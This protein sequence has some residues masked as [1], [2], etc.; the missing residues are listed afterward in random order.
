MHKIK[1]LNKL[2][3][4]LKKELKL[5][6]NDILKY[7]NTPQESYFGLSTADFISINQDKNLK[8]VIENIKS[9]NSGE[10]MGA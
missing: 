2:I 7:M 8:I 9:M 5:A 3:K 4:V 6:D 1:N 10:L